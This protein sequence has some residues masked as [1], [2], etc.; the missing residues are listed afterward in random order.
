MRNIKLLNEKYEHD[1]KILQD[2][3]CR[4]IV[5]M[6]KALLNEL[7]IYISYKYFNNLLVLDCTEYNGTDHKSII[8][9]KT[10]INTHDEKLKILFEI[11]ID[12]NYIENIF[13]KYTDCHGNITIY[14]DEIDDD[15]PSD[16]IDNL[17]NGSSYFRE[18]A[19]IIETFLYYDITIPDN[20]SK[21][22]YKLYETDYLYYLPKAITFYLCNNITKIFPRDIAK[23]I[24]KTILN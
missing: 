6:K 11:F 14:D 15:N 9:K 19:P 8:C 13:I 10:I 21:Y 3:Y 20:I 2:E 7:S 4:D 12:G 16:L 22:Y 5:K 17:S 24:Y 18:L 23:I 1:K